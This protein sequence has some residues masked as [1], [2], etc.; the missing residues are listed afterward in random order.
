MCSRLMI[1]LF[2]SRSLS[3][4]EYEWLNVKPPKDEKA[5]DTEEESHTK[6]GS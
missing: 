2:E 5:K 6:D 1:D 3:Q 4:K